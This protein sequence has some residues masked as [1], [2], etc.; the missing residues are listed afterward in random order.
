M[1]TSTGRIRAFRADVTSDHFPPDDAD[2]DEVKVD[3][4]SLVFVLSA[5][6]PGSFQ[7]VFKNLAGVIKVSRGCWNTSHS[8]TIRSSIK[9][10]TSNQDGGKILFRDYAENDMAMV[11]F[12][13]GTKIAERHYLRQ[14]GTTSY[15][16]KREEL[17]ALAKGAGMSVSRCEYVRRRTVNVKEGIDAERS[18]LQAVMVKNRESGSFADCATPKPS[19]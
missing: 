8:C 7:Q 12:G 3:A 6:Y 18:F 11:R 15:F 16:F 14:D 4:V 13:P 19:V 2:V 5:I 10:T 1:Y 9:H 17:T